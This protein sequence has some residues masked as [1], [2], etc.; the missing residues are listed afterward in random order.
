MALVRR[1]QPSYQRHWLGH[2]FLALRAASWAVL[3]S[4]DH[5]SNSGKR[6]RHTHLRAAMARSSPLLHWF[7]AFSEIPGTFPSGIGELS[8]SS[9]L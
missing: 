7:S 3:R 8:D 4:A 9:H 5:L 2:A 6:P 1:P